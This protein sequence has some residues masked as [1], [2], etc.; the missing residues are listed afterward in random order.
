MPTCGLIDVKLCVNVSHDAFNIAM[1]K[2]AQVYIP[3]LKTHTI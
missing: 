2:T 3:Q 1:F